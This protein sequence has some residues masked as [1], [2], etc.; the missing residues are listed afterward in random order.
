MDT[1]V[2]DWQL[3]EPIGVQPRVVGLSEMSPEVA[4]YQVSGLPSPEW[5]VIGEL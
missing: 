4:S 2:P 1:Q 3:M 5:L